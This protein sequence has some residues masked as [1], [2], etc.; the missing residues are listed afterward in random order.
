VILLSVF[1]FTFR[2][3]LTVF[4]SFVLVVAAILIAGWLFTDY[5]V[6]F[7]PLYIVAPILLCGFILPLVKISGEKRIAEEKIRSLEEE[8]RRLL[9]LQRLAPPQVLP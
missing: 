4:V 3:G 7:E 8:N 6:L 9:D 5:G 1:S 2:N